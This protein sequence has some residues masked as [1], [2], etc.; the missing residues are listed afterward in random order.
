MT[1]KV[2]VRGGN[3]RSG[4]TIATVPMSV[5]ARTRTMKR[6]AVRRRAEFLDRVGTPGN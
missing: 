6:E 1:M 3:Q 5:T 2:E 4:R